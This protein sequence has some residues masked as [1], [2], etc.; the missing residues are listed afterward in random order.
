MSS[1]IKP[2]TPGLVGKLTRLVNARGRM[3]TVAYQ[4]VMLLIIVL[5]GLLLSALTA[6]FLT[7]PNLMNILRQSAPGFIIG[8]GMTI[9]ITSGGIDLSVGS[10]LAVSAV[11]SGIFLNAGF[12]ILGTVVTV[13]AAGALIG[14]FHGYFIAFRNIPPFITTLASMSV[15]RGLALVITGGFSVPIPSGSP[16]IFLGRGWVLG[17]PFPVW[18][19]LAML[20]AGMVLLYQTRFGLHVTGLGTNEEAVRRTGINVKR[21][22]MFIYMLS[23]IL[24]ALG[25][26]VVAARLGSGS[27]YSGVAFELR[28]IAAVIVGGTLLNGGSGKMVGTVLGTL[29]VAIIGNGLIQLGVDAFYERIVEGSILLLAITVN[30]S[31]SRRRTE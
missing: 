5:I 3:K 23:G 19:S 12:G 26:M 28:V 20:I 2:V 6:R 30:Q 18:L 14:A 16:F 9:V 13:L 29:L 4:A 10:L 24:A 11:L 25:G 27:S 22:K 15:L 31:L 7:Y 21:T 17:V 1:D 8:V